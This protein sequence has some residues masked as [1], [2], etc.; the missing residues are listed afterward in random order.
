MFSS[1]KKNKDI[2]E[3][4]LKFETNS[5]LDPL[6]ESIGGSRYVLLGEASHGTHEYYTWTA[7]ISKRLIQEKGF[8][9]IAVEGDWP[10]CYKINKWIKE[11]DDRREIKDVLSEFRRWPTWMWANWEIAA[12]ATWL[13]NY[14]S[15]IA[16]KEKIGFYGLDVYSL[17]ESI[18]LI[19]DYLE[20]EDPETAK[21]ARD[22]YMCFEP[23]KEGDSYSSVFSSSKPGCKEEV[24]KLLKEVRQNAHKYNSE[25]EAD[26]NAEI[27][28]L[29]L[30]NAEKYYKAMAGFGE[31][32]WNVRDRHMV[33]T[34]NTLTKYH[35]PQSKVIV[36]E[37]N[38]HIG[39]ARAT[40]M[41]DDGLVNVGQLVREQHG[42]QGV[43]LA[44]FGS[45]SGSVIAGTHWGA[46]MKNMRV[47]QGTRGSIEEKLHN[48][49]QG[50]KLLIL[51]DNKDLGEAFERRMGHRAIGVVYH[52]EREWGNY[53]PTKLAERYDAFLFID[54]TK[55]LHP[56]RITPDGNLTPE[57]F[58]FGI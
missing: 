20:K 7:Q 14:N 5:D 22:A 4:Y 25:K 21:H 47:P 29:V 19:V 8:S 34:L 27:N 6:L 2:S 32:S 31:D 39:D 17:W 49:Q 35:G 46:P 37:H 56:L 33:E 48:E 18:D 11:P 53:V 55:A 38:T 40:D 43:Y 16:E 28:S 24:I 9:F 45:Y 42:S 44:G 3:H 50:N 36:W 52:P 57:T 58:P 23:Y 1:G 41:A 10:D 15:Q 51:K 30:A 26:L 12:F 13:R 54:E